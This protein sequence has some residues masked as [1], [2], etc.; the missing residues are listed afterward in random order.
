MQYLSGRGPQRLPFQARQ[1]VAQELGIVV[2]F[3]GFELG[4]AEMERVGERRGF[5]AFDGAGEEVG[6]EDFHLWRIVDWKGRGAEGG[7]LFA[8]E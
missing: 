4:V 6:S 8:E 2:H 5:A 7:R 3:A 1:D